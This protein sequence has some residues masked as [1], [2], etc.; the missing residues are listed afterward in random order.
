MSRENA[1]W[2]EDRVRY[3]ELGR[4][5]KMTLPALI[6]YFQDCSIFQS[7]ALGIGMEYLADIHRVWLLSSWQIEVNRYPCIGE[8]LKIYTWATDFSG[9]FGRR[10]FCMLDE[11]GKP[12]AIANSLW[13]YLDLDKGRPIRPGENETALYGIGDPLPMEKVSRKISLP[14]YMTEMPAF[15]AGICQIDTNQHV[16]NC[17]YVQ[18]AMDALEI[19]K[20]VYKVRVEYK[21][22]ARYQDRI[23]PKT[24]REEDRAVAALCDEDGEPYAIVEFK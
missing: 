3:S 18:M 16:N 15:Q 10:N 14:E 6:D 22:A 19:T 17:Q 9:F 23:I 2:F 8:K 1:Y 4:D 20:P 12:A 24:A 13:T 7:E 11:E 21:K 5:L